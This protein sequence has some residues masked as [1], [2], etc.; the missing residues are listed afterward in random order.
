MS[1]KEKKLPGLSCKFMLSQSSLAEIKLH[2][3]D[4]ARR[5]PDNMTHK[6]MRP[7]FKNQDLLKISEAKRFREFSIHKEPS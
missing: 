2:I 5:R 1:H 4:T 7:C 3:L 6:S